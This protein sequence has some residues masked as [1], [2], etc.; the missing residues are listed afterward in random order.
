MA[1]RG[2]QIPLSILAPMLFLSINCRYIS[3]TSDIDS[4]VEDMESDEQG[5]QEQEESNIDSAAASENEDVKI[6]EQ[7]VKES[8][9]D[10]AAASEN[11]DV[12]SAELLNRK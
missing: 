12:K 2:L 5:K 7:E 4:S 3:K 8:N 6:A 10:S 9:I 11:E 1:L